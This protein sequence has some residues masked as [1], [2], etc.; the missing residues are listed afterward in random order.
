MY[1]SKSPV[2]GL[3]ALWC[4]RHLTEWKLHCC[5]KMIYIIKYRGHAEGRFSV[6][7]NTHGKKQTC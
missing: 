3:Q 1:A 4:D 2:V 7:Y 6:L 5:K